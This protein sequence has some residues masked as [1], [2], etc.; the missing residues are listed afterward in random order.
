MRAA[1]QAARDNGQAELRDFNLARRVARQDGFAVQQRFAGA[2]AAENSRR[3]EIYDADLAAWEQEMNKK[4][5]ARVQDILWN[6]AQAKALEEEAQARPS[7]VDV[8]DDN[9]APRRVSRR[10]RRNRA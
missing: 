3:Q 7:G 9:S 6:T 5:N 8:G 1:A 4:A 10:V 2:H